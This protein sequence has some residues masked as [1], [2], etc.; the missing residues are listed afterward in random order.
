MW[1]GFGIIQ[2]IRF[3][4][5]L[6]LTYG[7]CSHGTKEAIW[8]LVWIW[9]WSLPLNAYCGNINSLPCVIGHNGKS[10]KVHIFKQ[11]NKR[12][13]QEF[14]WKWHIHLSGSPDFWCAQNNH[15][16]TYH[17]ENRV[18]NKARWT[19]TKDFEA[20]GWFDHPYYQQHY[21]WP[22]MTIKIGNFPQHSRWLIRN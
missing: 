20:V 15:V 3:P 8:I 12:N 1:N 22:I 2:T 13:H 10:T 6:N 21:N 19:Q 14:V 17:S 18:Q 11:R 7:I 9:P 4:N 16:E 5:Y